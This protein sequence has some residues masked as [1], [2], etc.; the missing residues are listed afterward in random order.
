MRFLMDMVHHNP[1]ESEFSS[2]FCKP[3]VLAEYGY[4]AQVN[5]H[6]NCAVTFHAFDQRIMPA[7]SPELA[8]VHKLR[9]KLHAEIHAAKQAGLNVYYHIDLF[10]L[11][12]RLV[13]LYAE[14]ICDDAGRICLD[15]PKTLEV[16]RALLDELFAEFPQV[17]GVFVRVGETY[18]YDAPFHTGNGPIR[19][20]EYDG[21]EIPVSVEIERYQ[22]LIRFLRE[23]I[24]VRHKKHLFFRTWD[25]Y[26]DKFHAD[27]GYYLSVTDA[28]EPHENLFFSIKHT[29]LDFW[30]RV[31]VN[32]CIGIGRHAQIIEVQC[33][34]EYE[35]KGA[36][37]DYIMHGVIEGFAENQ[38]P[39][40][41]QEMIKS[42]LVQGLFTWS[43]G[44]GW[45]GP[46]LQ[47]ELWCKLN[48][49]VLAHWA[50][51]PAV[52]ERVWFRR[53]CVEEMHLL[54]TDAQLVRRICLASEKAV[55]HGRYCEAY[56]R[57]LHEKIAPTN[58]WMRDDRLGGLE[59]LQPVTRYLT[60]NNL[61]EEALREKRRSVREW[62]SI[63]RLA[64]RIT[65]GSIQDRQFLM[66]SAAYGCALF[67]VVLRAWI[68]FGKYCTK[69]LDRESA[70]RLVNHYEKAWKQYDAVKNMPQCATL[71]RD[72]YLNLPGTPQVEGMGE[73][74][75]AI[76][77]ELGV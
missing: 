70:K 1:G 3:E 67:T 39:V 40:G 58:L 68:L 5:K 42:P 16:Q 35:G 2:D 30:R 24:C 74:V 71:Y 21:S 18:L 17:D 13:E 28:I 50:Q 48:V 43:R 54:P 63:V 57:S 11:P 29:A 32:P 62:Q 49:W 65:S 4:T 60:E 47:N 10:V 36:Y 19:V 34:R 66:A 55:L 41:L 51:Q 23:E 7:G 38:N 9:A 14:E 69:D 33:Q 53:F 27:A 6:I 45:Y 72:I 73:S 52:S 25:C 12:K 64:N 22:K 37:P 8:W 20:V 75:R 59:Q 77:R 15:R 61:W 56:D 31:R 44:G 26:P 46:Y 76:R